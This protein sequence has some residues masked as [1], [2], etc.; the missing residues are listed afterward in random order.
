MFAFSASMFVLTYFLHR[1][2]KNS[3]VTFS[4]C[5]ILLE[6]MRVSMSMQTRL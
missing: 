2:F 5:F 3:V 4:E 1:H 6:H